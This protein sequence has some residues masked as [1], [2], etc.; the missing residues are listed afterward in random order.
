MKGTAAV[1]QRVP[2]QLPLQNE[3]MIM[4]KG[5]IYEMPWDDQ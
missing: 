3:V 1:S 5:S 4:Y 2:T